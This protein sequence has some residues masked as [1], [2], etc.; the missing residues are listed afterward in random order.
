[1]PLARDIHGDADFSGREPRVFAFDA[2]AAAYYYRRLPPTLLPSR[3]LAAFFRAIIYLLK[4][5]STP[6]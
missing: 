1:M 5:L 4:P 2:N 3:A 6:P